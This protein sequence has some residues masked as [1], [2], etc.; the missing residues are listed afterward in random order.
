MTVTHEQ[1]VTAAEEHGNRYVE[2]F[3]AG[4]VDAINAMY[5]EDAISV[6]QPGVPLTGQARR[7]NLAEFIS[8]K[9]KMTANLRESHVT[10]STALLVVDWQIDLV[11]PE[12][13][14]HLEGVGLD[15]LRLGEDGQWRF[16]I[17]NPFG[18]TPVPA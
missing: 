11:T 2:A 6:W 8:Q 14:E 3:N 4:D 17:D 1:L 15:V 7:D 10:G 18:Q 9:P 5:T 12:G 13:V 16:A